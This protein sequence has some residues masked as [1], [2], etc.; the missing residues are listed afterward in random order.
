MVE[1][2]VEMRGIVKRFG[3]V[4]ANDGATFI[5]R[6]GEIHALLGENG[7]GKSTLMSILSG[8]YRRDAGE[9][10]LRGRPVHRCSPAVAAQMGIGMVYQNFRLVPTLTPVEN[11][12]LGDKGFRWLG[13]AWRRQKEAELRELIER[14]GLRFPLHRPV[15][16]L[17]LGEQQR[18]EIVKVLYRGADIV[19]LDE[20]TSVLTPRE[21]EDLF[22]ALR[23]M[24]QAGKTVIV[25]THK[26]KEVMAWSDRITV[27]RKG[28]T[29]RTM[30]T[31]E[32]NERELARLMV[33]REVSSAGTGRER[34]RP[35]GV[36]LR[37]KGLTALGEQGHPALRGID[38]E[39]RRGEVVG[40]AGVAGNGQRE[41]AECL[42]G[43]RSWTEGTVEFE[44]E[45][46]TPGTR[47]FIRRGIAH[48]PEDRMK[49]GLAGRLSVFD[50]LL[51]KSYRR[52]DVSPWGLLLPGR[53]REPM[54]TLIKKFEVKTPSLS[55]PVRQ[56]S[57]GNQ[58]K[59]LFAREVEQRPKLMVAVHPTQGLDVGAAE[60]VHRILLDLRDAG[61]GIVLISEDLDE[62]IQLSD[63]VVVISRGTIHGEFFRGRTDREAIGLLMAGVSSE[64]EAG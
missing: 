15:Q 52:K 8:L 13:P 5:A 10:R 46:L 61:T 40:I 54:E 34:P 50:N 12:V 59:L 16:E 48:I 26:L 21:A 14:F 22:L 53:R 29:I 43:L 49:M 42:T 33:G 11:T 60:A 4:L 25:T 19:I 18:V 45:A 62:V 31:R 1:A 36:L 20:P 28:R 30:E 39:V 7:A 6:P 56:L 47:G 23:E 32:T 55:T 37:V 44:G 63:R 38:L 64:E 41:L 17:S 58:Q 57:G 2:S 9:I 51:L 24:K 3:D 35:G 27:M